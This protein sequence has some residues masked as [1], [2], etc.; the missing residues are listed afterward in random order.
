MIEHKIEAEKS[1]QG[2]FSHFI[3]IYCAFASVSRKLSGNH[4]RLA[5]RLQPHRAL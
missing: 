1:C 2:K 5:E 4:P 3:L